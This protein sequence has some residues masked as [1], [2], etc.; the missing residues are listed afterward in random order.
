[1]VDQKTNLRGYNMR[2]TNPLT[3]WRTP[4]TTTPAATTAAKTPA[5]QSTDSLSTNNS[6]CLNTIATKISNVFKAVIQSIRSA[7]NFLS[8]GYFFAKKTK[9]EEKVEPKP[10][11]GNPWIA[12]LP[13]SRKGQIALG[14]AVVGAG[15]ALYN[16]EA[17]I[18]AASGFFAK[19][20]V[21]N[22]PQMCPAY[23]GSPASFNNTVSLV[24]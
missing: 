20:V 4:N 24:G 12:N 8:C 10:T 13:K 11:A 19:K 17:I 5:A 14:A 16:R 18:G 9:T 23:F 7:I 1:M 6:G 3:A 15:L 21:E 22:A 2:I